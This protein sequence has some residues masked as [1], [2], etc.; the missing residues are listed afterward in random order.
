MRIFIADN[1]DAAYALAADTLNGAV[2]QYPT[3]VFCLPT[4]GTA[5]HVYEQWVP[6]LRREGLSLLGLAVFNLD[7]YHPIAPDHP[8]SYRNYMQQRLFRFF[9]PGRQ[10][11]PN[12]QAPDP[13]AEAER[14]EQAIAAAGGIDYLFL[15]LGHNGHIAFNEPGESF[16]TRTRKIRLTESTIAANA[17]FFDRPQDVPTHA[18]TMGIRTI[19]AARHLLFVATGVGKAP[20]VR[21]MLE[22][23]LTTALPASV[24]RLHPDVTVIL[25]ADAAAALSEEARLALGRPSKG[26]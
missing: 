24:L 18:L 10:E 3:G 14:Y 17:R 26:E 7:E 5:A 22:G 12:G 9:P 16:G 8:E 21:A 13:D 23:P 4:G 20:A 25:D 1:A 6:A 19:M 15:T 2:R 11:I